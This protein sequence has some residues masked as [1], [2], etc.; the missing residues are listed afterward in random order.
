MRGRYRNHNL[1]KPTHRTRLRNAIYLDTEAY[2]HWIKLDTERQTLRL[3]AA[4]HVSR[5]KG[6]KWSKGTWCQFNTMETINKFVISKARAKRPVHV[7]AH[8]M[9]YDARL[10]GFLKILPEKGFEMKRYMFGEGPF[11]FKFVRGEQTINLVCS[12]NHFNTSLE[13]L[14]ETFGHAKGVMPDYMA[15]DLEWLYYCRQDVKVLR[16]VIERYE[17]WLHE[18]G[19]GP[20]QISVASQSFHTFKKCFMK[21][22]MY[23]HTDQDALKMADKAYYGGRTEMFIKGPSVEDGYYCDVNAMYPYAMRDLNAPIQFRDHYKEP[24]DQLV[25]RSLERG[26]V[27]GHVSVDVPGGILP[28]VIDHVLAWREGRYETYL[29]DAEF[30]YAWENGYITNVHSLCTYKGAK[31]F[32]EFVDEIYAYRQEAKENGDEVLSMLYKMLMN[33]LYGKFAQRKYETEYVRDCPLDMVQ[34]QPLATFEKGR[35]GHRNWFCGQ[36]TDSWKEGFGREAMPEIAACVTSKARMMMLE[37]F[38]RAGFENVAY[39]DTDSL[40]VTPEGYRRLGSP[41][42]SSELGALCLEA[43]P[44]PY[45]IHGNKDYSFGDY[46][47]LKGVRSNAIEVSP[48]NYTHETWRR[49][50]GSMISGDLCSVIIEHGY[51]FLTGEYSKGHAPAISGRV[52]PLRAD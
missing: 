37:H 17:E 4:V 18:T 42:K 21:H 45:N 9:E 35:I 50:G 30:R 15:D 52:R 1:K 51:K 27:I 24:G 12:L 23:L 10:C 41:T 43:G 32:T 5:D 11:Y 47:K 39:T 25:N 6:L 13:K 33:S 16:N 44:A 48:N 8:N 7:F 22:D 40:I 38:Q 36:V 28:S 2:R 49:L 46:R 3:G 29:A 14:G 31:V 34:R 19:Y 20:L 26:P